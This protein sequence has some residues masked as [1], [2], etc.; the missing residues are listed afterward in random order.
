MPARPPG[1][2]NNFANCKATNPRTQDRVLGIGSVRQLPPR[3]AGRPR[4]LAFQ[5]A[6]RAAAEGVAVS[7]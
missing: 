4:K 6:A 5:L 1:D 2:N 3:E 7:V